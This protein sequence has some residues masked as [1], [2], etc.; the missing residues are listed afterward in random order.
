MSEWVSET[1]VDR[2]VRWVAPE[3]AVKR[4]GARLQ[5]DM[6]LR[7]GFDAGRRDYRGSSWRPSSSGPNTS[8]YGDL[9]TIRQ[10]AR[11][12]VR[13]NPL[14]KRSLE[15][16]VAHTVGTGIRP[17]WPQASKA[18][19]RR[20]KSAW[21]AFVDQAD[22]RK[23]VDFYGLQEQSVR[24]M[25]E[26]GEALAVKHHDS[27]RLS[28]SYLLMEGDLIDH[29]REGVFDHRL[30]RLGVA[31]TNNWH[32]I[33]G[34]WLFAQN[35]S[36]AILWGNFP[37]STF[38]PKEGI[39]HLFRV[40]RIGQMR[41]ISEL[42]SSIPIMRDLADYMESALVKARIEACFAAFVTSSESG[43]GTIATR[44][45]SEDGRSKTYG[46]MS[47][48]MVQEL[49]PG[50]DIKFG[51]PSSQSDFNAFV[52]NN[53]MA[54]AA[55][56]GVTYDQA[57]GD[58]RQANYSSLRAG[59]IEFRRHIEMIQHLTIIPM[60]LQPIYKEFID[61]ARSFGPLMPRDELVPV[62][63]VTPAW[64]PI[65]PKKDLD[66]DIMAVRSG[67]LTMADFIA[68]W[69]EDPHQQIEEIASF[70][71]LLDENGI[72]LDTDPRKVSSAGLMQQEP[73]GEAGQDK[74]ATT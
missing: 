56:M 20:L 45:E 63:W 61:Y 52:L 25:F 46:T 30:T 48:G 74:E 59:K 50:E 34:Y 67:R 14:A 41:G 53:T 47:P 69:G 3:T 62:R 17:S 27:T 64:E 73:A 1:W 31:L 21:D 58:L 23:Q 51:Q 29:Q 5:L 33:D 42:A 49:R 7:G 16:L 57:T 2:I 66:A 65:D 55:G 28:L 4:M 40:R 72:I 35:P 9:P 22:V 8:L 15:V 12:L 18:Q 54:A 68:S 71:K 44:T 26:S 13:N 32:T 43:M 60:L 39:H 11:D 36:D 24:A 38:T 19:R 70:N 6:I 10:R 37:V